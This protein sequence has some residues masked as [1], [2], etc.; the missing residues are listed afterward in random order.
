MTFMR[1]AERKRDPPQ[2]ARGISVKP[3]GQAK[4]LED[5]GGEAL[6]GGG[7]GCTGDKGGGPRA[8]Q[9]ALPSG[10]REPQTRGPRTTSTR[11]AD[12]RG[13]GGQHGFVG[14]CQPVVQSP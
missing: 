6:S 11:D 5:V 3:V 1:R 14:D 2:H 12:R 4:A 7:R 10:E 13:G 8:G 9:G